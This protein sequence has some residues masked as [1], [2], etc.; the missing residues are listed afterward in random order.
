L[1]PANKAE[2]YREF[3]NR[4]RGLN[5]IS[6]P[7]PYKGDKMAPAQKGAGWLTWTVWILIIAGLALTRLAS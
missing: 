7:V 4:A 1:L 2:D 3:V 6:F 5:G